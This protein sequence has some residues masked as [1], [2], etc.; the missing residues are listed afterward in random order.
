[1]QNR[2]I[3]SW[4]QVQTTLEIDINKPMAASILKGD[5]SQ[6]FQGKHIIWVLGAQK[7]KLHTQLIIFLDDW[8]KI[9]RIAHPL[10]YS[11]LPP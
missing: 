6:S 5:I 8:A 7:L 2:L 1:M 3:P 11:Y 10:N 4:K 9:L